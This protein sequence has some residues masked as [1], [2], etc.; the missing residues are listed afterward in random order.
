M[1][2]INK[3]IV[4]LLCAFIFSSCAGKK[5]ENKSFK[6]TDQNIIKQDDPKKDDPKTDDPKKDDPKTDDPKKDDPKTDDPK[7]DDPKKD[8]PKTD[9]PKKDDPKTDDPKK[10]DPKTDDPK[11]DDPKKDD[12]K[13][14]EPQDPVRM[15]VFKG[16]VDGDH[17]M[18][19]MGI[20]ANVFSNEGKWCAEK[21]FAEAVIK[22]CRNTFGFTVKNC[23]KNLSERNKDAFNR[24]ASEELVLNKLE[25]KTSLETKNLFIGSGNAYNVDPIREKLI[26]NKLTVEDLKNL[27]IEDLAIAYKFYLRNKSFFTLKE[28]EELS[29]VDANKTERKNL[30]TTLVNK[31]SAEK[32]SSFNGFLDLMT[33]VM[34]HKDKNKMDAEKL[35]KVVYLLQA[36]N[37]IEL[38]DIAEK[39]IN[40]QKHILEDLVS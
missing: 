12:P 3:F 26:A 17:G 28:F 2:N 36:M 13:T 15:K 33:K 31:M 6:K 29:K 20:R 22:T 34:A 7:K 5:E 4:A 18:C 39:L 19:T 32:R 40:V 1:C 14:D 35:A 10:D 11:K 24:T 27:P 9:D 37:T 21:E 38:K 23:Y 8:D 25:E 30:L 16:L